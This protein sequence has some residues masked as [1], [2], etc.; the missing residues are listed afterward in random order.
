MPSSPSA[1]IAA[2]DVTAAVSAYSD[3]LHDALR[4]DGCPP[5]IAA[6]LVE[7]SA[8]DLVEAARQP[9]QVDD[10]AGW[11][12]ARARA[13]AGKATLEGPGAAWA[14]RSPVGTAGSLPSATPAERA[15]SGA[16]ARLSE[17]ER[18]AVLL[19]D[20]HDLSTVSVAVA[21]QRTPASAAD[22]VAQGRLRLLTAYGDPQIPGGSSDGLDHT[23]DLGALSLLAEDS[24]P[25][26]RELGAR[27]ASVRRHAQACAACR[28]VLDAQGRARRL[29]V[30]LSVL[31]LPD[32]CREQM[33]VNVRDRAAQRLPSAAAV[34]DG[35][36]MVGSEVAPPAS[37]A[38]PLVPLWLVAV[39]LL[40]A[41]A[42]GVAVGMLL[43]HG[44]GASAAQ[45]AAAAVFDAAR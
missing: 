30:G 17:L 45:V 43:P 38:S 9:D 20:S 28:A 14:A 31:A 33:L 37:T 15:V 6:E 23:V 27:S 19:R 26:A 12:F 35:S 21:L 1:P 13:L 22:I 42:L 29:L 39:S 41:G 2:E 40:L 16:L 36:E 3:R 18:T 10:L 44:D 24:R 25:G 5:E 11:W 4:R 7:S 32:D 34:A 8:L